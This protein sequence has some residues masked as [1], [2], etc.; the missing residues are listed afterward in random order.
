VSDLDVLQR[1]RAFA[2]GGP[3]ARGK[4]L[5]FRKPA[6]QDLRIAF[7]RMGGE[8]APWGVA[9]A[10]GK[11]AAEVLTVAE[12]RDREAVAAMM[13][14]FAPVLLAHVGHPDH[15]GTTVT[16]GAL[17]LPG[18]THLEML[19][20]VAIAYQAATKATEPRRTRLRALSR[21]ATWLFREAQR[22][23]QVEIVDAA[24]ALRESFAFPADDIRQAHL[25]FLLAWL[26]P[27]ARDDR[28][29][30]AQLAE[31]SSVATTLD[32]VLERDELEPK[33]EKLR[34]ASPTHRA[35][36]A[37]DVEALL[38]TQLVARLSRVDAARAVIAGD[39]RAENPGLA[40]LQEQADRAWQRYVKMET[41]IAAGKNAFVP[42][43]VADHGAVLPARELRWREAYETVARTALTH[44]D[45]DLQAERVAAGEAIA[46]EVVRVTDEGAGRKT[47]PVWIV[48]S[49]GHG[50]LKLRPG[51]SVVVAGE[52]GRTGEIRDVCD[53]GTGR[54]IEV[55]ITGWKNGPRE[56]VPGVLPATDR[57]Q[58]GRRVILM[59]CGPDP[60][61][62]LLRSRYGDRNGPGSWLTQKL[63]RLAERAEEA[64]E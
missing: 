4:A 38:R 45:L 35:K 9:W 58:Q 33:V 42:N 43:P 2:A 47:V 62:L 46:G 41:D 25:G 24:W 30:Q 6:A 37:A 7:V 49:S 18:P 64:A 10:K 44:H 13:E 17:W 59:Q 15:A 8:S 39:P 19:H 29:A 56:P 40:E 48:E 11:A 63:E 14:A 16:R 21:A 32:P 3:V 36:L 57:R 34:D 28:L 5:H 55:E 53:A 51:S 1:V 23:G 31:R 27:G 60:I 20:N 61:G 26:A 22:P 50:P 54:R 52:H 12:A